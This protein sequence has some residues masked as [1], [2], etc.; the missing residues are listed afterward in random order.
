MHIAERLYLQGY[1]TYPRTETTSYPQ[2]FDFKGVANSLASINEFNAY[3]K[4]LLTVRK[5]MRRNVLYGDLSKM[6]KE[7]IFNH[8]INNKSP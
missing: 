5:V 4:K 6:A 2:K 7:S 8:N 1:I 3:C